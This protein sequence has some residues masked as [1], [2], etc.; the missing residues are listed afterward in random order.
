MAT[1]TKLQKERIK[2][3]LRAFQFDFGSVRIE[4]Q[5]GGPGFFVFVP[6]DSESYMQFC[7][8]IDYLN[9]WLYGAVQGFL[10]SE[11]R[12]AYDS[13]EVKKLRGDM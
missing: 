3:N 9:G 4:K 8:N 1:F 2:D 11:F 10:R 13:E 6:A 12:R 5:D 7:Y